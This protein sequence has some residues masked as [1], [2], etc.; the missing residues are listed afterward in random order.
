[1]PFSGRNTP[2]KPTTGVPAPK[3]SV[4]RSR[5]PANRA[6]DVHALLQQ[7]LAHANAAGLNELAAKPKRRSKRKRDYFLSLIVGNAV[8]LGATAIQP[9]FGAAGLIIFNIGLT[10][11]M[12]F[13][14]DDY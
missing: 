4:R 3:N 9:I 7:N 2:R 10:W 8:L 12:W 14:M 1:M 5:A 6:N 11:I 13:V